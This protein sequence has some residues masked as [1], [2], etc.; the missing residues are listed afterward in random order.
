[1]SGQSPTLL[2]ELVKILGQAVSSDDLERAILHVLDWTGCAVA[3][4]ASP[5]A[6]ILQKRASGGTCHVITG[7]KAEASEAALINGALGNVLEMDDVHREAILHPGPV[8]IPAALAAAETV[9]ASTDEFL[10]GIIKGYEAMIRVG[11]A[12][13]TGHYA[14]WHNTAT[15]GPFGAAAAA[16]SIFNLTD[17]QTVWLL[18]NAGSL[19]GGLWQMRHEDVMTKQLHAGRAA[20]SGLVAAELA[21]DGFT[22]PASLLDGPQGFFAA[23]CP[24]GA[25]DE[26]TAPSSGWLIHDVSFKPWPACRHAH[27]AIDAAMAV[28]MAVAG[29]KIKSVILRTYADAVK[30][31]DKPAPQTVLE[32]KFS[33]QHAV[34]LCLKKGAPALEDFEP[35]VFTDEAY[36]RFCKKVTVEESS[37]YSAAFPQHYGAE[38]DVHTEDGDVTSFAVTDAWGD[39]ENPVSESYLSKKAADLMAWGGLEESAAEALIDACLA[40]RQ[41][42]D[43]R[44]YVAAFPGGHA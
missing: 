29:K 17:E 4:A 37:S 8:V 20:Q 21:R 11:R 40:M 10:A 33:L 22:G 7:H 13:G 36:R 14:F 15:C 2:E 39:P 19:A 6:A 18:A 25:P 30:F 43:F 16:A 9:N 32:A 34:A 42:K 3:G 24:D 26:V 5:Q 28:R 27:A 44:Q 23:L 31:C 35:A 12:T 38:I 41:Q 1:M